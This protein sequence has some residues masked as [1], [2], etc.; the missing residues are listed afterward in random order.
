MN[1]IELL[2]ILKSDPVLDYILLGVYPSDLLPKIKKFPAALVV[3]LDPSTLPGS[4]WVSL[5]FD[6]AGNCEYFDSYGRKP[7]ELKS[8]IENNC[9]TYVY[10]NKQLQ[11]AHTTVCGQMCIYFLVWRARGFSFK[12][13]I[14]SMINDEFVTGFVNGLFNV[15]TQVYA[16]EYIVNQICNRL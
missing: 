12:E 3:N 13:I 11:N 5:Y 1:T 4:H 14:N 8:Y 10:N 16:N 6:N 2:N 7:S 9:E 15:H